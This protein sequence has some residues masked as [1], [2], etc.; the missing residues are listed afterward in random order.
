MSC[1]A[2]A[3]GS[4][5]TSSSSNK[6]WWEFWPEQSAQDE[7]D[8]SLGRM[9]LDHVDLIY[10]IHPPPELVDRD[11][12]RAGG[13]ADR[14]GSRQGV[15][16]RDVDAPPSTTQR[17]TCATANRCR[18]PC[19]AQ[20]ATSLAEHAGAR[21]IRRCGDAFDRG[22]IGLVASYVLAGG[23]LTG[24]YGRGEPGRA[25]DDDNPVLGAA[26][27][28]PAGRRARRPSGTSRRRTSP[29]PTPSSTR[30]LP[31]CCSAPARP[32]S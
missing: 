25:G 7:L 14:F 4:A 19:A 18:R 9:G 22:P 3:A 28:W 12:R 8:G 32:T 1:S 17:S 21:A 27:S 23:T 13:R 20:M 10:A 15:G 11:R 30:T 29:S 31:A 24:K 6:L 5:T 16:H 2:P 26:S